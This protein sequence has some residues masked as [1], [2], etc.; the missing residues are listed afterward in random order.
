MKMNAAILIFSCLT[1][2]VCYAGIPV[3]D[4]GS[5]AQSTALVIEAKNQLKEL[6]DQV[7]TAKSQLDDFKKEAQDTKRRLEGFTDYSNI[8][9]SAESYLKD[10]LSDATKEITNMD[11]LK[12]E[13]GIEV[14]SGT[15]LSRDYETKLKKL[16]RYENLQK[17][18]E[19]Q[20][21]KLDKLQRNFSDAE[22]PQQREEILN[23]LQLENMKMQNTLTSVQLAMS[24]E[25]ESADIEKQKAVQEWNKNFFAIPK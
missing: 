15:Q 16:E 13:H 18:L 3:I 25:K 20:S 21:G 10:T 12:A 23:N 1:Y 2:N 17:V 5:I 6:Q 7:K 19:K 11:A 9:G 4:A 8:F 14:S 24:Q 22:T